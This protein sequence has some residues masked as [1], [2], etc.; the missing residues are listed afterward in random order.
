MRVIICG[1]RLIKGPTGMQHVM[2]AIEACPFNVTEVISGGAEGVDEL[3]YAWA[4]QAG[5]DRVEFPGNWKGKGRAAGYKRNQKMAWYAGIFD[6]QTVP[7]EDGTKGLMDIEDKLKGAC[8]A[9][10]DGKSVGTKHMIDIA[11]EAGLP[12]YIHLVKDIVKQKPGRKPK[13]TQEA[14]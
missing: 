3:G 5:I 10:W 12:V 11:T 8:L 6:N 1:S 14:S 7:T 13:A 9:V 2:D 4:K